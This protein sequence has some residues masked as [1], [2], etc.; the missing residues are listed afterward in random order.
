MERNEIYFK[1]LKNKINQYQQ[2]IFQSLPSNRV[3]LFTPPR[4]IQNGGTLVQTEAGVSLTPGQEVLRLITF[5][6]LIDPML[7]ISNR[8]QRLVESILLLDGES[9]FTSTILFR[10]LAELLFDALLLSFLSTHVNNLGTRYTAHPTISRIKD[11][12]NLIKSAG[13]DSDLIIQSLNELSNHFRNPT[14][15]EQINLFIQSEEID[16]DITAIG[17][18]II[19]IST[20]PTRHNLDEEEMQNLANNLYKKIKHLPNWRPPKNRLAIGTSPYSRASNSYCNLNDIFKKLTDHLKENSDSIDD[21]Y[22]I[23]LRLV[24]LLYN[25]IGHSSTHSSATLLEHIYD[26]ENFNIE[27]DKGQHNIMEY[28][29]IVLHI[30]QLALFKSGLIDEAKNEMLLGYYS[31]IEN[32]FYP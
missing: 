14:K 23:Q 13:D 6:K 17:D 9:S 16:S 25:S 28:T 11:L 29:L 18:Q 19:E 15:I 32:E 22:V 1:T 27:Q 30:L 31:E 24:Y 20:N 2:Q 12:C 3:Q 21:D 4:Q 7:V 26:G 5:Y 10:S 8:S